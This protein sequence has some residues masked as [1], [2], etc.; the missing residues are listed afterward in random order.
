MTRTKTARALSIA[1]NV[2]VTISALST[3][4]SLAGAALQALKDSISPDMGA[5]AFDR[6]M[7]AYY[8]GT[9]VKKWGSLAAAGS[10][11]LWAVLCLA[12]VIYQKHRTRASGRSV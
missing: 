2:F 8:F 12:D 10:L 7:N 6:I 11:I 9:A 4:T 5:G 1:E 3:V